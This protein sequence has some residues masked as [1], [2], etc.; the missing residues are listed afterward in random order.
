LSFVVIV[1]FVVPA[2]LRGHSL[3]LVA[4][5]G[6]MAI[7]LVS[8]YLSHGVGPK[9]TAAVV[10]TAPALG[11]TAALAGGFVGAASLTG[12]AS[13]EA[14]SAS[15]AVGGLSLLGL[16]LAGIIIGGLGVLDDVTKSQASLVAELHKA[17]PTA[18]FA[19]LV[20]VRCGSGATT[21]RPP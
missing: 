2:I 14:L 13:E 1:G 7:M 5:T 11:L 16:L 8:L 9:T 19:A 20:G 4:V 10:G 12:L 17:N 15:F 3:V 6:A 18:G 21:S